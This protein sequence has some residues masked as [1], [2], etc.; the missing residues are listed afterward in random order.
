M[1]QNEAIAAARQ[2]VEDARAQVGVQ[3][4]LQE[5]ESRIEAQPELFEV[6]AAAG[7][8]MLEEQQEVQH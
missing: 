5:L 1:R 7:L 3:G 8:A 4:L 6:F 2:A